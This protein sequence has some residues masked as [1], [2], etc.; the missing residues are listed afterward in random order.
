MYISECAYVCPYVLLILFFRS[1]FFF[2]SPHFHAVIR[3][4]LRG[5][6][7]KEKLSAESAAIG[8]KLEIYDE[9]F[10]DLKAKLN[11]PTYKYVLC[12][13]YVCTVYVHEHCVCKV[14]SCVAPS[15]L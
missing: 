12:T 5:Q 1:F 13:Y 6:Q 7:E 4:L 15:E 8:G 11:G 14:C 10:S 3:E 9:K 2:F